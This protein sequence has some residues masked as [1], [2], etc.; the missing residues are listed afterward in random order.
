LHLVGLFWGSLKFFDPKLYVAHDLVYW[1]EWI[2][3]L[4]AFLFSIPMAFW[5]LHDCHRA[6]AERLHIH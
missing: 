1:T 5:D 3:W 6:V 2:D 4:F